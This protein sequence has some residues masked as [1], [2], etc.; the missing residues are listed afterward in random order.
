[1]R[2]TRLKTNLIEKDA[3]AVA[4]IHRGSGV[5]LNIYLHVC[6]VQ[7]LL[8]VQTKSSRINNTQRYLVYSPKGCAPQKY[9][10]E[11]LMSVTIRFLRFAADTPLNCLFLKLFFK[12]PD[13]ML[14][15]IYIITWTATVSIITNYPYRQ[16]Y[17]GRQRDQLIANGLA[18]VLYYL[19]RLI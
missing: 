8:R 11:R 7:R 12:P 5:R 4:F 2:T 19:F 10:P 13:Y 6:V 9:F 14:Y 17:N 18:T 15:N 3:R 1:M 16:I